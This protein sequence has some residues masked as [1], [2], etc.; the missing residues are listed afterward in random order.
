MKTPGRLIKLIQTGLRDR[1]TNPRV[2]A[3]LP[4]SPAS[5]HHRLNVHDFLILVVIMTV[6][7]VLSVL[8][9]RSRFSNSNIITIYIL[10]VLITSVMT[11]ERI[12]GVI[13]AVLYILL[14]NFFFIDPRFSFLVYD[15]YYMV[16]YF[17]SIIAAVIT[18]NV[19]SKMKQSMLQARMNA[20]Q[21]QVLL[22]ASEQLKKAASKEEIAQITAS[23]LCQLLR[24]DIVFYPVENGQLDDS[25]KPVGAS[26]KTGIISHD[27]SVV[28]DAQ[29]T[30]AMEE[31]L[32]CN[33][34]TGWGTT[35]FPELPCQFL[36]VRTE[37]DAYGV[38]AVEAE[39]R[40]LNIFEK[41]ILLSVIGE[42]ALSFESEK[43]RKGREEAQ[44]IAENEYFRSKLLRSISHDLRTPLTSI[45]GNSAN[46]LG[47]AEAFSL[48]ER[49]AIYS[50]INEDA[51]WLMD[52]VENLLSITRLEECVS[53]QLMAEVVADVLSA[54]VETA[55][56]H[57]KDHSIVLE[58]DDDCLV[59]FMDVSLI[60]QVLNNLLTNA[61]KYTPPGTVIRVRDWKEGEHVMVSVSD[62]GPGIS[63]DEK[64]KVFEL[65]YTGK[66]TC[67][68]SGRCLGLGLNLCRSILEAHGQTIRVEDNLPH[69]SVFIFSLALAEEAGI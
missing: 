38:I 52:L 45:I 34:R 50:D 6:A 55:K 26:M 25:Q 57:K 66:E 27:T 17:V 12:Y 61:V 13:S 68:D 64:Q 53:L 21:A 69:G 8:F 47:H 29:A 31:A 10:A 37:N 54:A 11:A 23:Q 36:C 30:A 16:T 5:Q 43:N 48:D 46:L 7:T 28:Q 19:S 1:K 59:A 49:M 67:A 65:F 62:E 15:P 33:H 63:D 18:S 40:S 14:F 3:G 42:C 32:R 51:T 41:N 58:C 39:K 56:R 2:P 44:I 24:R 9:D 35:R 20:Y 4:G 60:L 22:N